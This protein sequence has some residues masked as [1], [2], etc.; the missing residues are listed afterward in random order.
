[1]VAYWLGTWDRVTPRRVIEALA[2]VALTVV[3]VFGMRE[4]LGLQDADLEGVREFVQYRAE[5]TLQ[6]GSN[7]GAPALGPA[8]LPLAFINVWMRPFPWDVHNATS[9]FAA[10]EILAFWGLAW[11]RR[12]AVRLAL[13]RWRHHRLLRFG[14]PMVV[15]YTVMIGITFGNLGIIARQRV[16]VFP[17]MILLLA[18]APDPRAET[19]AR[20][21]KSAERPAVTH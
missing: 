5:Q 9:A 20:R 4:Q 7:I 6:G 13:T 18:A 15:V 14:L 17:F 19:V 12:R 21:P 11:H 16:L 10:I 1:M 2:A 3:A 8:A